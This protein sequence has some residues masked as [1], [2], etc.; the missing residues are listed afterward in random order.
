MW[1][2]TGHYARARIKKIDVSKAEALPGVRAVLTG[3][4]LQYKLGL[5]IVDKDI[6]AKKEVRHYGEAVAAVAADT[7]EIAKRAVDLIDVEYE[8]LELILNHMDAKRRSSPHPP[9]SGQL[10]LL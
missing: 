3:E 2:K 4:E 5:Y 8:V 10:R 7:L 9:G 1:R 6:L